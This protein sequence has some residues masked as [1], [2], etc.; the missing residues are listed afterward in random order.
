LKIALVGAGRRIR[1]H[2]IPALVRSRGVE[3]AA[4]F[5]TRPRDIA[6]GGIDWTINDFNEADVQTFEHM[7][8]IV[9]CVPQ[10]AIR[11]VLEKL[12][13][14]GCHDKRIFVDTP[15]LAMKN[16]LSYSI[17]KKFKKMS[18]LE[19]WLSLPT[20]Q[21]VSGIIS[22]GRVGKIRRIYFSHSGYRHHAVSII[23]YWTGTQCIKKG[24]FLNHSQHVK[25]FILRDD[26][27]VTTTIIEPREYIGGQF[28]IVG[29]EGS[30]ANYP[31]PATNH[32]WIETA[33]D[34]ETLSVSTAKGSDANMRSASADGSGELI[35]IDLKL[36]SELSG[37]TEMDIMKIYGLVHIFEH[38]DE[39]ENGSISNYRPLDAIYDRLVVDVLTRLGRVYDFPFL[40]TS[41]LKA[42]VKFF[43]LI[44]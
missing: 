21:L 4:V 34:Q 15:V 37:L 5:G 7:N 18:V 13:K 31:L 9:V 26:T 27:G 2:I 41:G 3:I 30:I 20:F 22:S 44:R 42:L 32:Y 25:E 28:L 17:L 40:D 35:K 16:V 6:V 10:A 8:A 19:D 1:S 36:D 23:R 14:I 38:H 43:S 24:R 39:E 33:R 12:L 29:E 11:Q